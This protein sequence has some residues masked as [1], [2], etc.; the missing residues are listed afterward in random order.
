MTMQHTVYSRLGIALVALAAALL[1]LR[2]G[3]AAAD[4]AAPPAGKKTIYVY[5]DGCRCAV[6]VPDDVEFYEVECKDIWQG[7]RE[8]L[9]ESCPC[10][11]QDRRGYIGGTYTRNNADSPAAEHYGRAGSGPFVS[12]FYSQRIL[13]PASW[14]EMRGEYYDPLAWNVQL[15]QSTTR[16]NFDAQAFARDGFVYGIE[17]LGAVNRDVR[18]RRFYDATARFGSMEGGSWRVNQTYMETGMGAGV[19]QAHDARHWRT[20]AGFKQVECDW[21]L[22]STLYYGKYSSADQLINNKYSGWR[23]EARKEFDP[24]FGASGDL[25]IMRIDV[26]LDNKTVTRSDAGGQLE[27]QP[28]GDWT[29]G[30]DARRVDEANDVVITSHLKGYT[31]VGGSV[32]YRPG[33]RVSITA[34]YHHR[35]A[36][37]ERI[38]LED[39]AAVPPYIIKSQFPQQRSD[40]DALRVGTT[41]SGDFLNLRGRF[42]LGADWQLSADYRSV[43]WDK[44]P[45]VGSF[46][47]AAPSLDPHY[48]S[49]TR[50]STALR[51]SREFCDGG[52]LVFDGSNL[53]RGNTDRDSSYDV[54]RYSAAYSA[55]LSDCNRYSVGLSHTA[56]AVDLTGAAQDWDDSSWNFDLG[57]SGERDWA[58]YT[59]N[60]TRQMV[61]GAWAGDY[62]ALGLDLRFRH[63]PLSLS[64]WWRERQDGLLTFGSFSD[65]GLRLGYSIPLD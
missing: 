22:D 4:D 39:P 55:P 5:R 7:N 11:P 46:D 54:R 41:A 36:D 44:L 25:D 65:Q 45:D 38:K 60:Y 58:S 51:L 15:D 24:R 12:D 28:N 50:V 56:N 35:A 32:N 59:I 30:A 47:N 9:N 31:D 52:Q 48:F 1:G 37:A 34:D 16:L 26:G 2:T 21:L 42:K 27:W 63:S 53:H 17:P 13:S 8:V 49:N 23:G 57:L 43:D 6:E 61:E 64:A 62:D 29:L 3:A 18:K 33:S 19:T 10:L 14:H 20:E 40:F